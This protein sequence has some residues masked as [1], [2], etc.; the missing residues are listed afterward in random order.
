MNLRLY[1]GGATDAFYC[2]N[3]GTTLQV[4]G[5]S[6]TPTKWGWEIRARLMDLLVA[7]GRCPRTGWLQDFRDRRAGAYRW[8]VSPKAAGRQR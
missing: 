4:G 1:I 7:I 6:Y 2:W 5:S 3:C 8:E